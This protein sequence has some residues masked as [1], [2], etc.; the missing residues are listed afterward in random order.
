MVINGFMSNWRAIFCG[1]LSCVF[2]AVM[3][4]NENIDDRLMTLVEGRKLGRIA[5][6]CSDKVRA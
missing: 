1:K 6:M 3:D 4:L 5:G 2:V